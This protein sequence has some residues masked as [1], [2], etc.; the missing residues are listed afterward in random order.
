MVFC[1]FALGYVKLNTLRLKNMKK[2][3]LFIFMLAMVVV[4]AVAQ[5]Q[6]RRGGMMMMM[7]DYRNPDS[8]ATV[9]AQEMKL[10]GELSANFVSLYATYLGEYKKI[11]EILP[12]RMPRGERGQRPTEEQIKQMREIMETRET[13][14]AEMRKIYD[15]K[16]TDLLGAEKYTLLQKVEQEQQEK[17]MQEMMKRFAGRRGGRRGGFGG[18]FPGGDG[19]GDFQGG[20]GF[21]GGDDSDGGGFG[22]G[23]FGGGF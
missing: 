4:T 18:G 15:Q 1:I 10:E 8:T 23:D 22:G 7:P 19:D 3:S 20:G 14:I 11:D 6:G 16:F 5:P 9:I 2:I 13:V 21:G 12:M 17:R